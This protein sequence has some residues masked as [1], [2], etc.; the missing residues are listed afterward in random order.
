MISIV[1][2]TY[3]RSAEL[4]RTLETLTRQ[5]LR[6]ERWECIVVDNNSKDDTHNTVA[7]FV[8]RNPLL[9]IRYI[10]EPQ[11]G[12]SAARNTGILAARGEVVAFVDD[13]ELLNNRFAEAYEELFAADEA[14]QAAGGRVIPFYPEGRPHWMSVYTERP[15]ANPT[16]WGAHIRD[17]PRGRIPAG[18]NMAFRRELFARYG[19]FETSLGRK[20]D[21]LTGGEE[22]ELFE[23]LAAR[24]IAFR[25]TPHAIIEHVIPPE[26]LT[27]DYFR[28]L[29]YNIGRSQRQQAALHDR[30]PRL[31]AGE[32]IKWCAT[33]LIAAVQCL[34]LHPSRA[35]YLWRMRRE[36]SRGIF[37]GQ[38]KKA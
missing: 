15:I 22:N 18:G 6:R 36:I 5:T 13:D 14:L 24:R 20:G 1:I 35:R 17:F 12:L 4:A 3:N 19:L 7:R 26:K 2:A 9:N 33:M 23:R 37:G 28:R 32:A 16:D 11:Q 31:Y 21:S 27:D 10:F 8:T 30:L 25:Y 29:T 38:I 34:T